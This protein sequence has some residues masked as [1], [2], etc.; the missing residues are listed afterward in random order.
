MYD[1]I[2]WDITG[3]VPFDLPLSLISFF[4]INGFII[5]IIRGMI[6]GRVW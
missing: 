5:K 2:Y 3:S 4:A 1:W 6:L